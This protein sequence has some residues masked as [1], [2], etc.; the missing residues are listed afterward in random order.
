MIIETSDFEKMTDKQKDTRRKFVWYQFFFEIAAL[1]KLNGCK[2]IKEILSYLYQEMDR[3]HMFQ[4]E[5]V[6]RSAGLS[7]LLVFDDLG[8]R[9][10]L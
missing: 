7:L 3:K 4:Y 10:A 9:G 1:M 5:H 2:N 8:I 6:A